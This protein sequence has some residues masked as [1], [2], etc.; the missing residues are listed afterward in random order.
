MNST[1]Q[2]TE[3]AP[4]DEKNTY[5]QSVDQL[6]DQ[7]CVQN[8]SYYQQAFARISGANRFILSFNLMAALLG[9]IW[10]A[11]R[12]L[13]NWFLVFVLLEAFAC[14]QISLG[15]FSDLGAESKQRAE[16]ITATLEQRRE[17]LASAIESG[18]GNVEGL[19]RIVNSLE[20]AVQ[21]ALQQA[22][23]LET[24]RMSLLIFG[25]V[26]MTAIKLIQGFIANQALEKHFTLWRSDRYMAHGISVL[27]GVTGLGIVVIVYGLA[28]A[29]FSFPTSWSGLQTFPAPEGFRIGVS[30]GLK[31]W[32]DY[33]TVAG[34]GFFNNITDSVRVLLD[35]LET[36]FVGTPWPV[37]IL[38]IA[39][40]AW[41][42][43]GPRVAIFAIAGLMYL[44]LLGFWDKA[45]A[46]VSLLGAA[47]CVSIS[48]GIPMG[49]LCARKPR[50]YTFIR[51]VLDFMQTMPS[52][53]YLIPIIAF[54][55]TGKPAAILATLV[56]GS[57]P[58]IRLT[59]LGL[60]GVPEHVREAAISFG[61]SPAYLLFKVDLPLAAKTIMT[62][63][64][65]TIMMSLAMVVIASLIGAKG[66]GEDVLE[67]LQYASTGEGILAGFAILICSMI[68][69]RIIQG[70]R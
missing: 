42:C 38:F 25:L 66:L 60:Q 11:A 16:R 4:Q 43:A 69:D 22:Q 26:V 33:A 18:T 58:V 59:V 15:L 8:S 49:I 39:L 57:P 10:F 54:F 48:L 65:Q 40:L 55:G 41:Q 64:N 45:M 34:S 19:T 17:Q 30:D 67:A 14:I 7:Y 53:V 47:A 3:T 2:H 32:F 12:G 23:L 20:N 62:G 61:A 46:T 27:R 29:Q 5:Q 68:L 9:P 63:V 37:V 44:G 52:F 70:K 36:L 50:V 31:S 56:F 21:Q 35:G 1:L 51:P 28:S 13:W 6:V 24:E